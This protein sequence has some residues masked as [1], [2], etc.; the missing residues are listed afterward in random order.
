M[1]LGFNSQLPYNIHN[2]GCFLCCWA[3]CDRY[4][5]K[6]TDPAK[7]NEMYK[8]MGVGKAFDKGGN[9]QP[10]GN[11]LAYGDIKET[12]TVTPTALTD[13]QVNTIKTSI[14]NGYPV[15]IGIDYDPKDVDYDSHFVVVVDYDP[16]DENNLTI[17]DPLGGKL[18]SLKDYLG[19]FKPTLR[20]TIESFVVTTGPK[21]KLTG[22]MIAVLKEH[23]NLYVK[24]HD[25]WHK[26]VHY[27]K[28]EADPNGTLFED[29][30]T[31][32]AGIKSRATDLEN[33]LKTALSQLV[34]ANV[35][36]ANQKDKLANAVAECQRELKIQKAEYE[37]KISAMPDVKKLEAQYKGVISELE[38]QLREAQKA[39]GLKDIEIQKLTNELDFCENGLKTYNALQKLSMAIAG[40]IKLLWNRIKNRK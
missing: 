40:W 37:A 39:G 36:V 1:F 26:L 23:Y 2:Y 21:P 17:A 16:S 18:R 25:Q 38:G 7:L 15:I 8:S 6:E 20:K 10:G 4:Y 32:I 31:I 14:D 5:G 22:E 13:E 34:E 29:I 30:Q 24:N 9:Y 12:R 33:Q 27:L 28:P 35:E 11:N 3:M 19:W